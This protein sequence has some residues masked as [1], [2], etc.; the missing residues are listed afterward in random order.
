VRSWMRALGKCCGICISIDG[1]S[2]SITLF[3]ER[4]RFQDHE[5]LDRCFWGAAGDAVG[6]VC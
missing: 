6:L 2:M 3:V 4:L 1:F 5:L